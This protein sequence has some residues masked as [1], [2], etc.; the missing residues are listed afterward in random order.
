MHVFKMKAESVLGNLFW[1]HKELVP[2]NL[3]VSDLS[4]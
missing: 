2:F 1:A 3:R 4:L